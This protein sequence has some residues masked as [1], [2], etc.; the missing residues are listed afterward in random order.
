MNP[1]YAIYAALA[2]ALI[3]GSL[4]G[5]KSCR[6]SQGSA[7][8]IQSAVHQGEANAH[9]SQ[10]QAIPEH[11]EELATAKAD[12]AGARAEVA[13]L[14][15]V[16]AAQQSVPV[17]DHEGSDSTDLPPIPPDHRDQVIAAQDV[18]ITKLDGQVLTLETSLRDE[19]A[20]SKQF[21]E[22]FE[23]ERKATAAQAAATEAWKKAVTASRWQGRIEGFAAGVALGY[24]GAKR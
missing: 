3:L 5:Y 11:S 22:A 2:A 19:Q 4:A 9:V 8:E 20:R 16:L 13:R 6:K 10:A 18:L 1:R 21:R 12:V 23:A 15:R 7:N 14:K 24:L 17:S